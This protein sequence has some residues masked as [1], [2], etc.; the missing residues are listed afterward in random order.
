MKTSSYP[1]TSPEYSVVENL[2]SDHRRIS[3]FTVYDEDMNIT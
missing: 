1:V 2:D 3:Y